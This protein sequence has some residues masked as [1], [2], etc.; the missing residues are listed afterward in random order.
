MWRGYEEALE[1]YLLLNVSLW[2][3]M[4]YSNNIDVAYTPKHLIKFPDW[5]GGPIHATHRAA[6]LWKDPDWYEQFG[7]IEKPVMDYYWPE[8]YVSRV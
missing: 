8:P 7:W 4:G 3:S 2:Q 5:L 6:L 1:H